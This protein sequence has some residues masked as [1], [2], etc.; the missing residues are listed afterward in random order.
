LRRVA[1][2]VVMAMMPPVRSGFFVVVVMML[3]FRVAPGQGL[4]AGEG[5][6]GLNS[7]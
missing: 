7:Q 4:A 2:S 5:R 1:P 3:L 6:H